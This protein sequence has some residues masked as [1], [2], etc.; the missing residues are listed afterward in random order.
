MIKIFC[1][2]CFRVSNK[3]WDYVQRVQ[4]YVST[5]K[6]FHVTTVNREIQVC[7][8]KSIPTQTNLPNRFVFA[9]RELA[10]N[11]FKILNVCQMYAKCMRI[12]F[13]HIQCMPNV[14]QM[15][16]KYMPNV[17]HVCMYAKCMRILFEC[18]PNK[19]TYDKCTYAK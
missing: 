12:I 4:P 3:C 15:Y 6:N 5:P 9:R 1:R 8:I 14:C 10:H 2:L 11:L 18:M 16:A 13:W 7:G 17:C 19:C